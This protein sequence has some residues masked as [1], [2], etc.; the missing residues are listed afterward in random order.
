MIKRIVYL[1]PLVFVISCA[2]R[3]PAPE[4]T[5]IEGMRNPVQVGDMLIGGQPSEAALEQLDIA[6]E[7]LNNISHPR[8][9]HL[10]HPHRRHPHRRHPHRRRYRHLRRRIRPDHQNLYQAAFADLRF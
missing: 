1:L 10:H 6:F 9:R 5:A 4:P 7:Q 3:I 2:S 8:L